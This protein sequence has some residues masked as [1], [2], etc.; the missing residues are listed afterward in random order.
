VPSCQELAEKIARVPPGTALKRRHPHDGLMNTRP[1]HSGQLRRDLQEEVMNKIII[2]IA[3][4]LFAFTPLMTPTAQAGSKKLGIGLAIGAIGAMHAINKAQRYEKRKRWK[5]KQQAR[6][7]RARQKQKYIAKQQRSVSKAPAVA[8]VIMPMPDLPVKKGAVDLAS[9]EEP[10]RNENSSISTAA[11][12]SV[13]ETASID[14][15]VEPDAEPVKASND[16]PKTAEKLDCK[17][18]FPSV[19]MTLSVPCE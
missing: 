12:P 18:F 15:A 4:T 10:T 6:R 16:E 17:K 19:G 14:T 3:A 2:A 5:K 8:K 9:I 11:L 13:E 1:A 7:Y